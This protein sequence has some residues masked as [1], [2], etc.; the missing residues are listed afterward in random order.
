MPR[1]DAE[2][3]EVML[4]NASAANYM[5]DEHTLRNTGVEF[6]DRAG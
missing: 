1:Y 5:Q 3:V 2:A 6:V 4:R